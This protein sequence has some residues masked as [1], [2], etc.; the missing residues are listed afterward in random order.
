MSS[1]IDGIAKWGIAKRKTDRD[2]TK[3]ERPSKNPRF[4]IFRVTSSVGTDIA[5][6]PTSKAPR[7]TL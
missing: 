6:T 1:P 7:I 3:L 5:K 4:F 2:I